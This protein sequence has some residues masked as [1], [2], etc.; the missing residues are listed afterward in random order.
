MKADPDNVFIKR[1]K[2][3]IQIWNTVMRYWIKPLKSI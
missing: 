3:E 1:S 2:F